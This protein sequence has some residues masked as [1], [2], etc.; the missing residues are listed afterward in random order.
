MQGATVD[1][2]HVIADG[3]GRE[4]AYVAMSRARCASHVYVVADDAGQCAEDLAAE[5]SGDRRQRWVLDVDEPSTGWRARPTLAERPASVVRFARLNAERAALGAVAPEATE[6]LQ[7]L[8]MEVRL[9]EAG[10]RS[11]PASGVGLSR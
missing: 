11:P 3:G 2:A 8:A 4:L 1:R 6:R 9:A 10:W 5:W 7:A